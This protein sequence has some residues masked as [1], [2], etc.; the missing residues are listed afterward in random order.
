MSLDCSPPPASGAFTSQRSLSALQCAPSH[1]SCLGYCGVWW[2]A[3][4]ELKKKT[5]E[6]IGW[7]QERC[8][9]KIGWREQRGDVTGESVWRWACWETV[10]GSNHRVSGEE[11]GANKRQSRRKSDKDGID[12]RTTGRVECD[13]EEND[14]RDKA[15]W[16]KCH[17][18]NLSCTLPLSL[19]YFA[20]ILPLLLDLKPCRDGHQMGSVEAN[21]HPPATSFPHL[22]ASTISRHQ[23]EPSQRVLSLQSWEWTG[24]SA[25]HEAV[26]RK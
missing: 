23:L 19:L 10:K 22:T 11:E 25:I 13:K 9:C 18:A 4:L 12:S 21:I 1:A 26:Y 20:S 3:N 24:Q 8:R 15:E 5:A 7:K 6:M 17:H 2:T 16:H 14:V